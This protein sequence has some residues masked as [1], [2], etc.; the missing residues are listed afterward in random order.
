MDTTTQH[1]SNRRRGVVLGTLLLGTF[2]A[3]CAE[4]LVVGLLPLI[5]SGLS[6]SVPAA[7]AL[8][9][10]NALGLAIGGPLL[11]AAT[12]RID[13]RRVLICSIGLFALMLAIPVV[14]PR[15]ELFLVA[16]LLG[17]AL[18]GLFMAAAF[19]T[20]TASALPHRAGQAMS[21]VITGFSVATVVGLPLSV[22]VGSVLGWRGA[23][24]VVVG[25]LVV[26]GQR[27]MVAPRVDVG[28]T[29]GLAAVRQAL[30]PRIVVVL[31]LG[32]SC[33]AGREPSSPT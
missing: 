20:A 32:A 30:S 3:G 25:A 6:V 12:I 5:S 10:T 27:T 31:G 9:S 18:Q 23:L 4:Q 33:S 17:G 7:G 28:S 24:L 2:M 21:V 22:L 1:I 13:R 15:Y 26:G 19:T 8:V 11:T 29:A 16:R 14:V